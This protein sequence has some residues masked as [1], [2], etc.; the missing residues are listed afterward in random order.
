MKK[1]IVIVLIVL[2][3][4]AILVAGCANN[5]QTPVQKTAPPDGELTEGKPTWM[6]NGECFVKEN[7]VIRKCNTREMVDAYAETHGS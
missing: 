1:F 4:T 7:D 3:M 6:A 5:Q 2:L